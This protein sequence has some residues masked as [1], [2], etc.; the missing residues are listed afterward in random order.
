MQGMQLIKQH[1]NKNKLI[2][3]STACK[4]LEDAKQRDAI[5]DL[6]FSFAHQA[7]D[8]SVLMVVHGDSASGR[9]AAFRG[10]PTV[11]AE[12][13]S[14]PLNKGGLLALAWKEAQEQVGSLDDEIGHQLL[15][16]LGRDVPLSAAAIPVILKGR[17]VMIFVGESGHKGVRVNRVTKIAEFTDKVSAAFERILLGKKY[18]KFAQTA[19]SPRIKQIK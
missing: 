19:I 17:V 4:I 5:I 6:F 8:F 14:V 12:A 11:S 10:Q 3:Y 2:K 15:N 7:F 1:E 18:S 9:L 13:V 16:Q